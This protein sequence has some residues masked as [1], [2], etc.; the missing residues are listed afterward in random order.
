MLSTYLAKI[1]EM[2]CVTPVPKTPLH[3]LGWSHLSKFVVI[4]SW[5]GSTYH[6]CRVSATKISHSF[7]CR[8]LRRRRRWLMLLEP[9]QGMLLY[10]GTMTTVVPNQYMTCI[11]WGASQLA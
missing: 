6:T 10:G 9:S 11:V 8:M 4:I 5:Q 1:S 7:C 2:G 3:L